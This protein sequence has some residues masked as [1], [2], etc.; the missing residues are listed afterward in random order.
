MNVYLRTYGCQMNEYDSELIRSVLGQEGYTFCT[1]PEDADIII[2]NTCA[3]RENAH[4]KV[5]GHIHALHH[6]LKGRRFV[7]GIL[8]CMAVNMKEGLM[9]DASLKI[10]FIAGPDSYR[11]LPELLNKALNSDTPAADTDFNEFENYAGIDPDRVSRVNAWLAIMRGCNNFCTFCVV[12]YTR[13][14]ER[15]RTLTD[16]INEAQKLAADGYKQ[17][18]LLGQNVNSYRDNGTDFAGLLKAVSRISGIERIR[19]MSP[20]PKD[21]LDSV[22]DLVAEEPKICKHLHLP[23]QAGNSRVLTLM[24]RTYTTEDFLALVK[25]IRFRCPQISLSTD[26]IVGFP[27]ET[28]AEFEDTVRVMEEVEF[29]SAFIFKYSPRK[30]TVA[31]KRY[32]DDINETVKTE[33][34]VRLNDIQKNISLKR[35]RRHIGEI[36]PVLIEELSSRKSD[37]DIQGR[38]DG[39]KIVIFPAGG[40]LALG[41]FVR[42]RITDATPH[43]LKGEGLPS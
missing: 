5:I 24:N 7:L 29:D 3:V 16:I 6:R 38:S 41:D 28:D 35:N 30:G 9:S 17:V 40:R 15:S 19:F 27:T 20:H 42:V 4:R 18:T 12:P 13:G 34:I 23:L 11:R 32:P 2:L 25:K 8:G 43:V 22:I 26:V 31:Q 10:N 14:R 39:N 1:A 33:R 36:Q 21:F 37:G